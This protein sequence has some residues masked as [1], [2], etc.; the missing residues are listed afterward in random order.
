MKELIESIRLS[1]LRLESLRRHEG[2]QSARVANAINKYA[3]CLR[4]RFSHDHFRTA[5][6]QAIITTGRALPR[7]QSVQPTY[8]Q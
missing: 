7:G 1:V 2:S 8:R 3:S 4:I 5:Y 6:I